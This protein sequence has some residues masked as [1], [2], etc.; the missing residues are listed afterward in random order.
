MTTSLGCHLQG[1]QSSLKEPAGAIGVTAGRDEHVNDL[2][3]LVVRAVDI[4]PDPVD[5]DVGFID[6]P[7]ATR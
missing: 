2:P 6:E 3:V 5:L 7:P 4:P 1:G